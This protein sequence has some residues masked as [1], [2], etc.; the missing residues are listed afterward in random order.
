MSNR[1]AQIILL[2][3]VA[4]MTWAVITMIFRRS[5]R[6]VPWYHFWDPKSGMGGGLIMAAIGCLALAI[7]AR[8]GG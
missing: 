5:D 3:C 2:A 4:A 8:L 1:D 6:I 7:I